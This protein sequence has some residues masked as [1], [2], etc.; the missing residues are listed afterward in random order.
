MRFYADFNEALSE[1]KSELREMGIRVHTQSVQNK[2]IADDPDYDTME[3]QDYV[4]LVRNPDPDKI[5]AD[6][7][8]REWCFREFDERT[9]GLPLNPGE[10]W[11]LR[12]TY[13]E[14][15]LTPDGRFD[16]AYPQRMSKTLERV[17]SLLK[18]DP[19]TRRAYLPIFNGVVDRVDDLGIRIPCSLG[20][21]F[22]FRQ[23]GLNITYYLRSSDFFEHLGNDLWL[24]ASLQKYVA[25]QCNMPVGY[26]C[27]H[28]GSLHCFLKDV[29]T[30]F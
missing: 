5:P 16:Y 21:H 2:N 29:K 7:I 26:F 23:G 28:V 20:Y 12:R 10:A 1:V 24:A 14:Q 22:M 25:N 18:K 27:H 11:K 30:V 9:C 4:Y 19:V 3:L 8:D 15:F 6:M 17:I 13:W